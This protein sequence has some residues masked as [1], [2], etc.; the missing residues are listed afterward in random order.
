M[1][2]T[3]PTRYNFT[4]FPSRYGLAGAS[5]QAQTEYA[6][7]GQDIAVYQEWMRI[8][9]QPELKEFAQ[10][11]SP[12]EEHLTQTH[13]VLE[14]SQK[15]AAFTHVARTQLKLLPHHKQELQ[16]V[17]SEVTRLTCAYWGAYHRLFEKAVPGTISQSP[18]GVLDG[19]RLA[20]VKEWLRAVGLEYDVI[21][22]AFVERTHVPIEGEKVPTD[23]KRYWKI[24]LASLAQYLSPD[25]IFGNPPRTSF[26]QIPEWQ[27]RFYITCL[28]S[29][30]HIYTKDP[31]T[32]GG[33]YAL[34]PYRDNFLRG[35]RDEKFHFM[36][37][38][39]FNL[40][41]AV[42]EFMKMSDA[43]AMQAVCIF[44]ELLDVRTKRVV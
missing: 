30:Y 23:G 20:L 21:Q 34:H 31:I 5:R 25:S 33:S 36:V 4:E 16:D 12:P 10:R 40:I 35:T 22:R 43:S 11:I 28:S 17:S 32:L 42:E 1:P 9:F 6:R 26:R 38:S 37:S 8:C 15:W 19:R 3:I 2:I 24:F 13:Y 29:P 14:F 41:V 7:F 18:Y 39:V 44:I 27:A